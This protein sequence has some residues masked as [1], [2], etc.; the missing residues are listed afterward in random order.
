M[1]GE[2]MKAV[3][4]LVESEA[5]R[6]TTDKLDHGEDPNLILEESRKGMEIIGR[7][8][9]EGTSSN[10]ATLSKSR[11]CLTIPMAYPWSVSVLINPSWWHR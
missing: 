1:S 4:D 5:L 2:L 8:F 7:R 3:A 6:I 11:S 9:S 10:H